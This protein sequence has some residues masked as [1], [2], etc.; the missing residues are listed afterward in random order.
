M[1]GITLRVTPEILRNKSS[2]ISGLISEIRHHFDT[3][4]SVSQKTGGYWIGEA[5]DQD[6]REYSQLKDDIE[7]LERR[8]EEHPKDLL[9]MAGLYSEAESEAEAVNNQLE[10]EMII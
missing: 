4:E 5:G 10:S 3:I 6:R 8:L 1:A 2:E 7:K 9:V